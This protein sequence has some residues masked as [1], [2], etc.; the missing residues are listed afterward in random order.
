MNG[1]NPA[2][3]LRGN[4]LL[5][6]VIYRFLYPKATAAEV[7]AFLFTST[8]P[9]EQYRFFSDSQIT[10]AEK[11]LGLSRK[12]AAT[13]AYQASLPVNI[14]KRH[15]FW[16]D[17]YPYGINGTSRATIIDWDEAGIFIESTNHNWGKCYLGRHCCEEGP[18]N[19]SQ[20]YSL[21]AAIR[22][23]VNGGCWIDV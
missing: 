2:D 15:S 16:N 19:H 14:A 17:P 7:N 20:K 6:L 13:T 8:L 23:G 5:T 21:T 22:G 4:K 9:G 3:V 11:F 10:A 12:K 18:Y 1:N